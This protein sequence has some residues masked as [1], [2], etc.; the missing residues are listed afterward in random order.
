MRLTSTDVEKQAVE[1]RRSIQRGHIVLKQKGYIGGSNKVDAEATTIIRFDG[2]RNRRDLMLSWPGRTIIPEREIRCLGCEEDGYTLLY[3]EEKATTDRQVAITLNK[4]R[5]ADRAE[6]IDPRLLGMVPV[7]VGNLIG[8]HLEYYVNRADR[9]LPTVERTDWKGKEG[10]RVSYTTLIGQPIRLWIVPEW[11]YA[12][13]RMELERNDKIV[14][15]LKDTVE[16]EYEMKKAGGIWFPRRL[17]YERFDFKKPVSKQVTDVEVVSLNEPLP[18]SAFKLSGMDLP[19]PWPV[20]FGGR[21]YVWD[22]QQL[23]PEEKYQEP[24]LA[25]G[26]SRWLLIT[27]ATLSALVALTCVYLYFAPRKSGGTRPR[28]SAA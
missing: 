23:V 21:P 16:T 19:K 12:V 26:P 7:S 25:Q 22:G 11:G 24:P 20:L 6:F 8:Y 3:R 18:P 27:A 2:T 9:N 17:V 13:V 4:S 15:G 14:Q 28:P 1:Y 10:W 5:P